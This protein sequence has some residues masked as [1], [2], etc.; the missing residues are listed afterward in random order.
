MKNFIVKDSKGIHWLNFDDVLFFESNG[1][2]IDVVTNNQ[3]LTMLG[4]LIDLE[5][6]IPECFFRANRKVVVNTD[7]ITEVQE[8]FSNSIKAVM[9]SKIEVE[10]SRRQSFSF[11]EKYKL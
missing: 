3:R 9:D 10:F 11:I 5:S 2:Y 8:W 4:S 6:K 1:N 7:R